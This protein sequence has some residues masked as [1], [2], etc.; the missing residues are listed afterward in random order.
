VQQVAEE[1]VR[2]VDHRGCSERGE[3]SALLQT[4]LGPELAGYEPPS[5]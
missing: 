3:P 5:H 4:R 1:S 2:D